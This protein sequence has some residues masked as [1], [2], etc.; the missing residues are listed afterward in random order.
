M[1]IILSAS[2]VIKMSKQKKNKKNCDTKEFTALKQSDCKNKQE[3]GDK[4]C[5]KMRIT[6]R[7]MRPGFEV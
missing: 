5:D 3:Q 7:N 1:I 2:E 4:D 6:D